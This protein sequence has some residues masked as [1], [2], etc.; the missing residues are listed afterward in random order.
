MLKTKSFLLLVVF[1]SCLFQNSSAAQTVGKDIVLILDGSGSIKDDEFIIQKSG[2][3]NALSE[4]KIFPRDG[5]IS[6]TIIQYSDKVRAEIEGCTIINEETIESLKNQVNAITQLKGSTYP[7][8]GINEACSLLENCSNLA[9]EQVFILTTDDAPSSGSGGYSAIEDA[10]T[11]CSI[12]DNFSAIIITNDDVVAPYINIT[13]ANNGSTHF[14]DNSSRFATKIGEIMGAA[15][16]TFK[17]IGL[18]AVQVV[19]SWNNT[20]PM[21]NG[22]PTFVRAHV[23]TTDGTTKPFFARLRGFYGNDFK[24]EFTYTNPIEKGLAPINSYAMY[25]TPDAIATRDVFEGSLNFQ[26]PASWIDGTFGNTI[27]LVLEHK[28]GQLNCHEAAN[29]LDNPHTD[30]EK[31]D[32]AIGCDIVLTFE[33]V[34]PMVLNMVSINYTD[35][36]GNYH[37][38]SNDVMLNEIRKILAMMPVEEVKYRI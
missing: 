30:T 29:I 15:G 28:G 18:E 11:S 20:V 5:S 23:Q 32:T 26:L 33:E 1:L 19:Q 17:L 16:E 37:S 36:N 14:V 9:N 27:K 3:C 24:E 21:I 10:L 34:P 7:A 2:I 35:E 31:I 38:T 22:K 4:P 6:L 12:V 8:L 13:D 25:A